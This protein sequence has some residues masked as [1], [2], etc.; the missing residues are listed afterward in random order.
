MLYKS[1]IFCGSEKKM[2]W[3]EGINKD[4]LALSLE[5]CRICLIDLK[6]CQMHEMVPQIKGSENPKSYGSLPNPM[7]P[8]PNGSVVSVSDS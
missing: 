7:M 3:K 1:L 6:N 4:T 5:K 2:G 8:C